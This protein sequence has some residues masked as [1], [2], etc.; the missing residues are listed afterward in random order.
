MKLVDDTESDIT[1]AN[2][3]H[4]QITD[5]DVLCPQCECFRHV[6]VLHYPP[7]P[8]KLACQ[9]CGQVFGSIRPRTE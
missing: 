4:T 6:A 5:V 7:R 8:A 9:V 1:P 2:I 3:L